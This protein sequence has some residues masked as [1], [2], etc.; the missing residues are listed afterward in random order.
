MFTAEDRLATL[1]RVLSL[2]REDQRLESVVLVG[3]M[4]G[5]PDRWSDIDLEIAVGE[6][7]QSKRWPLVGCR[8]CTETCQWSTT[9][10]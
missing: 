3:S 9:T 2:L 8:G 10:R 7:P 1:D 5:N 6:P 4:A